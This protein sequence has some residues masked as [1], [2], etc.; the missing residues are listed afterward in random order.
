MEIAIVT[1]DDFT[2]LDLFAGWVIETLAGAAQKE[3][4]L[5]SV[6]P[7]DALSVEL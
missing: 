3:K 2:D 5:K 7:L 6:A 4:A 1:F